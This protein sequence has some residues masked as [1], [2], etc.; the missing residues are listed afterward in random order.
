L[1]FIITLVI[2]IAFAMIAIKNIADAITAKKLAL[3]L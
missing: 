2:L 1:Q 3:K